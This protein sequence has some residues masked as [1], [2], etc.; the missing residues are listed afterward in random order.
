MPVVELTVMADDLVKPAAPGWQLIT[1]TLAG[2]ALI[3]LL[4]TVVK[5]TRSWP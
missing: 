1:A 3:V 5:L 2:I 4:I